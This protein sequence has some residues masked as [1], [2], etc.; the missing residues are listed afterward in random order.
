MKATFD[1]NLFLQIG[2]DSGSLTMLG[3]I[4]HAFTEPGE[5]RGALHKGEEVKATFFITADKQSPAAQATIDLA[6]LAA[7]SSG[8]CCGAQSIGPRFTVNPQGYTLFHVSGGE[9]GYYVHVRRTDDDPVNK[10]Y[11]SRTLAGGDIFSAILLRPGVYRV[12]NTLG[13]AKGEV[14]VA[15]P[16][17][18]GDK[19]Y[20][21]P[22]PLRVESGP[23]GFHPPRVSVQPGQGV[24][25]SAK[26]PTRIAI[27]LVKPDDGPNPARPTARAG[28]NKQALQDGLRKR[29]PRS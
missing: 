21:P 28:W 23:E 16:P 7:S 2:L 22:S 8:E 17:P 13:K 14:V 15:Y 3:S 11:D 4:V 12:T 18:V 1:P 29:Q 20:R 26:C 19:P 6:S 27:E 5:Y 9:G 24:L 10:G 25:F